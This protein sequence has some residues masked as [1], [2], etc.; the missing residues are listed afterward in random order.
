MSRTPRE[1]YVAIK[2]PKCDYHNPDDTFFCGKC[3]APLKSSERVSIEHIETLQAPREELTTGSTFDRF[4]ES[5]T[6]AGEVCA[7][8]FSTFRLLAFHLD[9]VCE[10]IPHPLAG[11]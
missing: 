7:L 2:C 9:P 5:A 4:L 8:P 3:A 1:N 10:S 11:Q 6:L